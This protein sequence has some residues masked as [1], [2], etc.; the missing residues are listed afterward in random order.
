[1]PRDLSV[2]TFDQWIDTTLGRRIDTMV[3]PEYEIGK[4]AVA[5]LVRKIEQPLAALEPLALPAAL[6]AGDTCGAAPA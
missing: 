5:M 4:T 3:L 1:V 2:I 6:E